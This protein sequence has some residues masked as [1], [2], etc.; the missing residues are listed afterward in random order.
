[1]QREIGLKILP[2][3]LLKGEGVRA[4]LPVGRDEDL[5][6]SPTPSTTDQAHETF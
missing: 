3:L 6:P 2:L 4:C 5:I 1:M